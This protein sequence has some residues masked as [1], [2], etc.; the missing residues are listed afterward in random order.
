M[1]AAVLGAGPRASRRVTTGSLIAKRIIDNLSTS[2]S[3]IV[4]SQNNMVKGQSVPMPTRDITERQ[5]NEALRQR[6]VLCREILDKSQ[7]E[8]AEALGITYAKYQK[9]ETRSAFPPY[10]FP[11]LA[12]VTGRSI[13]FLVTG[14]ERKKPAISVVPQRRPA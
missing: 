10:L 14:R 9:Y 11:R 7:P 6:L 12:A 3:Q 8:M 4:A 13:E 2:A 5:Y 1:A